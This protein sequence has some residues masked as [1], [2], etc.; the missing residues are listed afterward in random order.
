MNLLLESALSEE[1]DRAL[2]KLGIS[3][4]DLAEIKRR[5]AE[6]ETGS[7]EL[8]SREELWRRV[9]EQR[10]LTRLSKQNQDNSNEN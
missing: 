8:I 4:A 7:F 2:R 9:D 6:M 1:F 3:D 5:G 10:R